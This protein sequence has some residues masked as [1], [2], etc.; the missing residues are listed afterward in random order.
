MYARKN[1]VANYPSDTQDKATFGLL[2]LLN[3]FCNLRCHLG[4]VSVF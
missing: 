3:N 4:S 1:T 2:C